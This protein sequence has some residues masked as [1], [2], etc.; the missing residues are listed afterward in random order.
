ML[1]AF[2][3]GKK[4]K[5][6]EAFREYYAAELLDRDIGAYRATFEGDREA[7]PPLVPFHWALE[8]PE[9]FD[10]ERPGFDA[11]V[12]N[13]PFA[14]KNT[15]LS[16]NPTGYL[17]WLK[18]LHEGAHGNAD[19]V[20]HFYRRSFGL[21]REGGRFGLIATNTIRQGDTR[22]TGLR[23][24]CTNGGFV[25]SARTRVKWPG[26]AAVVVCVV[27]VQ[28][29]EPSGRRMID[30][31]EVEQITA[32]LVERGGHD[33]PAKL[34]ANDGKSFTGVKIYGSGFTFDDSPTK[35]LAS[36]LNEMRR[37]IAV[38]DSN[39]EVIRP[40]LGGDEVNGS[41]TQSHHRF[42]IDLGLR[43]DVEIRNRWP[44]LM[45]IVEARVKPDRMKLADGKARR[46]WWQFE[47]P[48]AEL[49]AVMARRDR[50]LVTNAG[51]T[52]HLAVAYQPTDRVLAH[53]L[54]VF[55]FGTASVFAV[56]QA[57][58]H[59]VWARFFASS[60]K[61]DL[62]YTP[63]DCFDTF[64]LPPGLE[65]APA[66]E[67]AGHEYETF[68]ADLMIRHD[69]GLTKTYNRFHDPEENDPGILRLRELHEAMD[70]AVLDAYGWTDVRTACEFLLDY[71]MDDD[72]EGGRRRKKPWR[73]RWPNAVRDQVLAQLL[74]LNGE[75]AA[76]E[77]RTGVGP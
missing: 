15:L 48:R 50:V 63:S 51:A 53:T 61:D 31:R 72:E 62:R 71:E 39:R 30:G 54:A 41:P 40:Y 76:A 16:G 65:T 49:R 38:S 69:E 20:A 32:Y 44:D 17:D 46:L 37:L 3:A 5:E 2:F 68:R 58:P 52:P 19:L 8:M 14:G 7:S 56:L 35:V 77:R 26:L 43:S 70:R 22:N 34:R 64:P 75:R 1:H 33:D 11:I 66:L 13:P 42:V 59:E 57:R 24:I 21:L 55:P 6:R 36:P 28:K 9:V 23:W 25:S 10:R 45:A 60:M 18:V 73:Y 47:R 74:A 29:G 4:A 27:H 12:G 67:A